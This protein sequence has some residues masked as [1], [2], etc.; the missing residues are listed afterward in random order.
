MLVLP[1]FMKVGWGER[2]ELKERNLSDN[3]I[4]KFWEK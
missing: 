1:W 4:K 3:N 2:S